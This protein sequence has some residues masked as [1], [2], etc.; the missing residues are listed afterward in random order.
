[1]DIGLAG[2]ILCGDVNGAVGTVDEAGEASSG[3]H[4]GDVCVPVAD[5][6]DDASSVAEARHLAQWVAVSVFSWPQLS[7]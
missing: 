1:M 7:F 3:L 5:T 2:E 6:A 4:G